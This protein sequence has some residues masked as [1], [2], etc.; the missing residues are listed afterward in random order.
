MQAGGLNCFTCLKSLFVKVRISAA[1]TWLLALNWVAV[2]CE[3]ELLHKVQW[4][5]SKAQVSFLQANICYG[6][7]RTICKLI[8]F[9]VFFPRRQIEGMSLI[10]PQTMG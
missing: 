10:F 9:P 3:C 8:F 5:H 7:P 4:S 2:K 1:Q 6:Y